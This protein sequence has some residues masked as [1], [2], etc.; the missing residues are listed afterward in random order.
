MITVG[1]LT[2]VTSLFYFVPGVTS[3]FDYLFFGNTLGL[4]TFMGLIFIFIGSYFINF[5]PKNV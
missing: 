5:N 2:K 3:L 4:N 1:E